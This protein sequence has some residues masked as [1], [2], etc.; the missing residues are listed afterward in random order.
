MLDPTIKSW[1]AAS[2]EIVLFKRSILI[3]LTPEQQLP[4]AAIRQNPDG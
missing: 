1:G 4:G 2:Y 3:I